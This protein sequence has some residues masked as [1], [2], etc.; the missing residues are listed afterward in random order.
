V[1]SNLRK[2]FQVW[3]FSGHSTDV[4]GEKEP[5]KKTLGRTTPQKLVVVVGESKA[6]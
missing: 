5:E 4:V 1:F 3:I 6:I 2:K